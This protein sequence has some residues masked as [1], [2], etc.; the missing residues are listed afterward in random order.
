MKISIL[1]VKRDHG[2]ASL[3]IAIDG[4]VADHDN[5]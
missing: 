3:E 5:V 4:R 1:A 2:I